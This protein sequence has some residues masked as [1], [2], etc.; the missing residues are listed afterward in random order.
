[1]RSNEC[2]FHEN[3]ACQ[4]NLIFIP[5]YIF[6]LCHEVEI[7]LRREKKKHQNLARLTGHSQQISFDRK[8]LSKSCFH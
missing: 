4:T 5:E 1:M 3:K 8:V 6:F 7:M 2:G